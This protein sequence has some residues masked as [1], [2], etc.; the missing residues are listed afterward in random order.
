MRGALGPL[1]WGH[2]PQPTSPRVTIFFFFFFITRIRGSALIPSVHLTRCAVIEWA[3]RRF[4]EPTRGATKGRMQSVCVSHSCLKRARSAV[5]GTR[6]EM[7]TTVCAGAAGLGLARGTGLRR[8]R[9]PTSCGVVVPGSGSARARQT[10]EFKVRRQSTLATPVPMESGG[11]PRLPFAGTAQRRI[12]RAAARSRSA[13]LPFTQMSLAGGA[14][15]LPSNAAAGCCRRAARR[16]VA[17]NVPPPPFCPSPAQVHC[18]DDA[19]RAVVQPFMR[20]VH[21]TPRSLASTA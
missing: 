1:R 5:R 18:T 4:N 15:R 16:F 8:T 6:R 19:L 2:Q 3:P 10:L 9:E 14:H 12:D 7:L 21:L 17:R 20:V 13:P 11:T